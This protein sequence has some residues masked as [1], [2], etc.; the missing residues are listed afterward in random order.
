MKKL[1]MTLLLTFA[2]STFTNGV[3]SANNCDTKAD[4]CYTK[5]DER[6]GGDTYWDGAGRNFCK[7]GCFFAEAGCII[8]SWL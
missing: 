6:W 3:V 4:A 7:S 2:F 1:F 5:C 8:A